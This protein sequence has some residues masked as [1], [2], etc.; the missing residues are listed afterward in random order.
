MKEL[1]ILHAFTIVFKIPPIMNAD[2]L[3][4][5][6]FGS[7]KK[8]THRDKKKKTINKIKMV[9]RIIGNTLKVYVRAFPTLDDLHPFYYELINL[10]IGIDK[11][12]M[13]LASVEWARKRINSITNYG[14]REAK[15]KEDYKNIIRKVYGRVS[16]IIYEIDAS[17]KF[18]EE[19]RKKLKDVPSIDTGTKTVIIAGY[20]NVGKSSLLKMLSSANPEIAPYPFTTKG[21]IVGHI[22]VEERYNKKKIQV[23]EAPGLLERPM[24]KRNE[25]ER[26]GIIALRH[27][28]DLVIF[29]IDAS[30]HC[31]YSIEE[32]LKLLEEIKKEFDVDVIVVENKVDISKGKTDYM[33]ISCR[34]GTGIEE[35]K[36]EII[37]RLE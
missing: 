23:V 10:L 9:K 33:K 22:W 24:A 21:L 11:L 32:Q 25:I 26:Q 20:P 35:L 14:I 3:L 6:A 16:S 13:A 2:E 8:V 4:D 28:P 19:T 1:L 15:K 36:K 29:I 30:M 5:R 12:K 7:A 37:K 18:L 34:D 17:L 27:L 31:G